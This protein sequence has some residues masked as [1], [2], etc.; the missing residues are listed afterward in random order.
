MSPL[1]FPFVSF[2]AMT[3][4]SQFSSLKLPSFYYGFFNLSPDE[5]KIYDTFI[6]MK[7]WTKVSS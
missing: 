2:R 4:S 7:D 6:D 3:I 5:D 1:L